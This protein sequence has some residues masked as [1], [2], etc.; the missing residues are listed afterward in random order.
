MTACHSLV[1]WTTGRNYEPWN[2]MYRQWQHNVADPY[3]VSFNFDVDNDD[4]VSV[5]EKR[6]TIQTNLNPSTDNPYSPTRF[7][8]P[9][10][11][12][13][14]GLVGLDGTGINPCATIANPRDAKF[15]W[16][17]K[18]KDTLSLT[19]GPIYADFGI[20][21]AN[22]PTEIPPPLPAHSE[23][24]FVK[25]WPSFVIYNKFNT[26]THINQGNVF[27]DSTSRPDIGGISVKTGKYYCHI[28]ADG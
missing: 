25:V 17:D 23:E 26:R 11:T 20:S 15:K 4:D 5:D 16:M 24:S 8:E 6:T 9:F 3:G 7:R 21:P 19:Q 13:S 2:D 27:G 14:D 1:A 12:Q 28:H 18:D 22:V 10:N